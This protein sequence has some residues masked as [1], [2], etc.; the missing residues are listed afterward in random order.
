[1]NF[2]NRYKIKRSATDIEPHE[3]FLDGLAR[4]KEEELGITE[5]KFEVPLKEKISYVILGIFLLS[6]FILFSKT[7][8]LQVVEG[9]DYYA[10]SQNN[11][12]RV[13]L[14]IPERGIIYDK[15]LK[16]LVSNS[17]AFDLVCDKRDFSV[18]S[19]EVLLEIENMASILGQNP[20]DIQKI[21][22]ESN[23]SEVLIAENISHEKLLVL[24]AKIG[25]LEGCR[26]E[27]N[28]IR[29]YVDAEIFSQ[30]L[31]YTSKINKTELAKLSNYTINDYIGKTGIEQYYEEYLRG[32]PGQLEVKKT[33]VGVKKGDEV[34]SVAQPGD[35]LILNIDADLQKK[36]Y[37]ELSARIK[38]LNA[39]RGAAVAV[40]PKTGAVLAL[41]SYPS[42]DNNLFSAG[43]SFADFNDIQNNPNQP[44]FNRAISAQYP[45]GSTIKPFEA[46]GALAEKTISPDKKI[47]D[48]GYILVTSKYDSSVTYRYG[49][50]TPHGWVDMR[51]ALAVS[52]NIYFYTVGGGYEG[53]EGLGPTRIKKY[54]ELFGWGSKTGIDLPGEFAG[55]IPTPEW[56]KQNIGESWWDGDTYN[57][58]IGQ[59]YLKVTPL[60]VAMAY[61]AI[62]NGGTLYKPQIVSK[63]VDSLDNANNPIKSFAPEVIKS[64]FLDA[65][66]LQIV[67]DGMRDCVTKDYGSAYYLNN[68]PVDVAAKTGTAETSKTGIYNTWASVFGP[69][70]DPDIVFVA[71]IEGIEGLQ[72]ATLPVARNVLQ[73]YFSK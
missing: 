58:S 45:T 27:K 59:S 23:E 2:Q 39:K 40:N 4:D 21:V 7:F 29:N 49:G 6:A 33:A 53:Q 66:N 12:G 22:E 20:A 51:K 8:F 17:P 43:I 65:D 11:K 55:F 24:E 63:V 54:L 57:L 34:L 72:S 41:V 36:T 5:K 52:S 25:E 64:N 28:T 44:L 60:Q 56:K 69:Y 48:I 47:N 70:E 18:S 10:A 62:A 3:I 67:K 42:Y 14:I 16:K 1:M 38:L 37:E 19:Y 15:N 9:R 68:L 71:T 30:I 50:V 46:Y 35:N 13:S 73:W 26:I 61:S 32:T 31:G